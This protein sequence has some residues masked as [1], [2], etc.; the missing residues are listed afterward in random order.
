MNHHFRSRACTNPTVDRSQLG[1][2]N[3]RKG[4]DAERAVARWLRA[5]GFPHA[6]RAVRTVHTTNDRHVADPGDL[7]GTPGI[8]WQIKD[9][10]RESLDAWLRELDEQ[11]AAAR[12]NIGLLVHRRR[13]TADPGRWWTWLRVADLGTLLDAKGR[14]HRDRRHPIRME[15]AHAA[16]L[17]RA[18][19]YGE[20]HSETA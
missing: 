14:H 12:A 19:G 7:T 17:L 16:E 11:T 9:T 3:R 10:A 20:A 1:K 18:A 6:E 4:H 2:A 8:T 5:N 13:G 15:L